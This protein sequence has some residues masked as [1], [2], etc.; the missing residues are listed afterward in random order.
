MVPRR[1]LVALALLVVG[2]L[3][4]GV[5]AAVKRKA[6]N[7]ARVASPQVTAS[8][9]PSAEPTFGEPTDQ[10]SAEPSPSDLPSLEPSPSATP[11]PGSTGSGSGSG[12][13][14]G[15]SNQALGPGAPST[16]ETGPVTAVLFVGA[17]SAIAATMVHRR[18]FR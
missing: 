11:A 12:S 5:T 16:P 6:D 9:Q 1:L 4:V 13:G 18:F 7:D 14:S 8:S 10:P 3:G 15:G 17:F 2:L